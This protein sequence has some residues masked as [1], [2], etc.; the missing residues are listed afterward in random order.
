M[1]PGETLRVGDLEVRTLHTPGPHQGDALA[2]RRGQRVHRRHAVQELRRRRARA[3][4]HDLR[5]PQALDHGH[6][7]RAPARDRHPPRPHRA[8]DGRRGVGTNAFVRVWRGLD[9]EGDRAV[10][11]ARRARRRSC[12]S[13]TTT[14]AAT[15]PGCAGPTAPTTSSPA[16]RSSRASGA[17]RR[18][19]SL[20]CPVVA[21]A[22]RTDPDLARAPHG[23]RRAAGRRPGREAG[24]HARGQRDAPRRGGR[25]RR[26]PSASSRR[27][28]RSSPRWGR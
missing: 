15:R 27:P 4:P 26:W 22:T 23:D 20:A 1:S 5:G 9:P 12:C 14:T 18:G 25:R 11:R 2:A 7:A 8:H 21:R 10:H 28:S 13:A 3:R 16:R 6:A 19:A 17:A 24:R